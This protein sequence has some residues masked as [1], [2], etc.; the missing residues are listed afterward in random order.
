MKYLWI[1]PVVAGAALLVD[2]I[3]LR[4]DAWLSLRALPTRSAGADSIEGIE[5]PAADDPRWVP[6]TQQVVTVQGG[7]STT[8]KCD[9]LRLGACSVEIHNGTVFIGPGP[10]VS[11]SHVYGKRVINAYRARLVRESVK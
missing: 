9:M 8:A 10:A 1:G 6:D 5:M 3:R 7:K 4:R 11:N 2:N